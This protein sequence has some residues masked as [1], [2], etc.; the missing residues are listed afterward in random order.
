MRD[1]GPMM[2]MSDLSQFSW[3][4]FV[5]HPDFDFGQAVG[6]CG[7]RQWRRIW[8]RC[9]FGHRQRSSESGDHGGV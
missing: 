9:R 2:T 7:V 3:R 6:E 4:K 1:L 8:W 5:L